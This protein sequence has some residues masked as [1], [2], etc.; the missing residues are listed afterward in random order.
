M[1][2][3]SSARKDDGETIVSWP[4]AAMLAEA[5]V[6]CAGL[7]KTTGTEQSAGKERSVNII[8]SSLCRGKLWRFRAT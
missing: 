2:A 3:K 5:D 6:C 4:K 1:Y 8:S 7:A